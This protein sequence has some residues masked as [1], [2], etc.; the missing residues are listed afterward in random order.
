[1]QTEFAKRGVSSSIPLEGTAIEDHEVNEDSISELISSLALKVSS[2]SDFS[3]VG[4]DE[5]EVCRT[6]V[7]LVLFG[8]LS[9]SKKVLNPIQLTPYV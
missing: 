1:M 5:K 3:L 2:S 7:C 6:Q 4:E 9:M 8:Q